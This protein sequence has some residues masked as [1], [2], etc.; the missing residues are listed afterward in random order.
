MGMNLNNRL[1]VER[2]IHQR[3]VSGDGE[4]G[5]QRNEEKKKE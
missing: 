4:G 3:G 2:S 5:G 1:L